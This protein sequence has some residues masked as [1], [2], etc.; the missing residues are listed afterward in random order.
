MIRMRSVASR[1][2]DPIQCSA[3]FA[4]DPSVAQPWV[5]PREAQDKLPQCVRLRRSARTAVW[6]GPFLGYEACVPAQDRIVG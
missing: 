2:R 1:R 6:V 5:L 3:M 4:V